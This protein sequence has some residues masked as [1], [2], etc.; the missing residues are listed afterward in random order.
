MGAGAWEGQ[1]GM[2]AMMRHPCPRVG[3]GKGSGVGRRP[4]QRHGQG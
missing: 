2:G 4:W 3:A 1:Q